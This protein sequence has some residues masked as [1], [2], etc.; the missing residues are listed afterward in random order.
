MIGRILS[1]VAVLA[2]AALPT[3][4]S[5]G[6][7]PCLSGQEQAAVHVRLLQTELMMAG[8]SCGRTEYVSRYNLFVQKFRPQLVSHATALKDYFA[9]RY[10]AGGTRQL[11]SFV[12]KVANAASQR[13]MTAPDFCTA[14]GKLLD[15]V[16]VAE[17]A[18][19]AELSARQAFAATSGFEACS[20]KTRQAA[21]TTP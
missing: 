17:P 8:L 14:A 21:G 20:P 2:L 9:R 5:P 15:A 4:A 13:S 16:L 18:Q 6:T 12:T 10:G 19:L 7:R 1:A 3:A 11:D